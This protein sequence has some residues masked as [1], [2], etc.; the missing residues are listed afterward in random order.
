[1]LAHWGRAVR[2][3]V[4]SHSY[5]DGIKKYRHMIVLVMIDNK[6]RYTVQLIVE[7]GVMHVS[8]IADVGNARLNDIDRAI[9]EHQLKKALYIREVQLQS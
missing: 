2:N 3:C 9:V 5:A 7:N 6:P 1:M 8:Q 4:G